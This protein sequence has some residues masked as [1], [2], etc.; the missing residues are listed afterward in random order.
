MNLEVIIM[1]GVGEEAKL[2]LDDYNFFNLWADTYVALE[3]SIW[4]SL[5]LL[6]KSFSRVLYGGSEKKR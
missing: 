2:P 4:F 3:F 6:R 1:K 5:Q